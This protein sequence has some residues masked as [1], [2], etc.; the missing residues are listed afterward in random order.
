[1][2]INLLLKLMIIFENI[3]KEEFELFLVPGHNS[4]FPLFK[5]NILG[6][7]TKNNLT[8]IDPEFR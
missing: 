4:L 2:S 3:F 6:D 8:G 1:M 7:Y 5:D